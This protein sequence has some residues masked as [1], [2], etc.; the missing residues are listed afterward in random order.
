[1]E[2]IILLNITYQVLPLLIYLNVT[3]FYN[4]INS[5]ISKEGDFF[6]V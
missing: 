5:K 4:K 2:I 1:M 3:I 6:E